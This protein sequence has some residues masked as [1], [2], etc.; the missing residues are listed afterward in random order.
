MGLAASSVSS[1]SPLL[2]CDRGMDACHL[3]SRFYDP[4]PFSGESVAASEA[5]CSIGL[6]R[7]NAI[8][9]PGGGRL[10]AGTVVG[11]AVSWVA[12]FVAM[13]RGL[14]GWARAAYVLATAPY[15][16]LLILLV[17]ACTLPGAG[18]GIALLFRPDFARLLEP[19]VWIAASS[20]IFF[21]L[22][23]GRH[24]DR[25]RQLQ[26]TRQD[27][28][29]DSLAVCPST[30]PPPARGRSGLCIARALRGA[31]GS[32]GRGCGGGRA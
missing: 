3:V 5:Y 6:Q 1:S 8:G 24:T 29:A 32:C 26:H 13:R 17:R 31:A 16:L 30:A 28:R 22:G 18:D 11:L 10:A 14:R 7:S 9:A 2:Q 12:V 19:S 15:V 27:V 21:S 4:M 25:V 23:V 20:Q